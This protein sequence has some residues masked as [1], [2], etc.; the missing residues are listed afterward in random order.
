MIDPAGQSPAR[1]L[2]TNLMLGAG[3]DRG[4]LG[5]G[6]RHGRFAR[7]PPPG[8]AGRAPPETGAPPP[9]GARLRFFSG[10][11]RNRPWWVGMLADLHA[12]AP[13][14]ARETGAAPKNQAAK[15]GAG[16]G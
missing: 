4:A 5:A 12:P 11:Q 16:I 8:R 15:R 14:R 9:D 3:A 1:P 7:V 6:D 2:F 10:F 13:A